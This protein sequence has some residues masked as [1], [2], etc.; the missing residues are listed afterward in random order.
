MSIN[1][2]DKF[3]I[4]SL[5]VKKAIKFLKTKDQQEVNR[6]RS[7]AQA[8]SKAIYNNR[9]TYTTNIFL[10][11]TFLCRNSCDYCG[12]R[13]SSVPRGKEY[14]DP[15]KAKQLI[16]KAKRIGIS[17][18]LLTTGE[19][20]EIDN[21]NARKW[22]N[23][24]GFG[25]TTDYIHYIAKMA[26]D[27]GL[28]P[29]INAG[30]LGTEDF[31]FLRDVSASM[32]LMLEIASSRMMQ[33]GMP[34]ARSPDKHPTRRVL[35]LKTAGMLKIPFTSGLLIG[36]G[37][38]PKEI[39]TSLFILKNLAKKYH[40]LQE[41][42]IQN[43]QPQK[44]SKMKD[45]SPISLQWLE[46][47]VLLARHILPLEVSLQVPP[48]LISRHEANFIKSGISDW[49]G[50][51]PLTRDYINPNYEW[52]QISW[53][54]KISRANGFKLTERLPVYPSFIKEE[55]V[56]QRVFELIIKENLVTEDG[57]RKR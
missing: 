2:V 25:S 22:L 15:S 32:G 51:S 35:S 18:V 23:K 8:I 31:A 10:P 5:T 24:K 40:H 48:N 56:S 47:I 26:L 54:N 20:P 57:Y 7:S 6:W 45:K 16:N 29:H 42:I 11:I 53:L 4:S 33:K 19:K 1:S 44:N 55:W 34:H 49:G 36:I 21:P 12:F 41:V 50:I 13:K 39:V 43:F 27:N 30:S 52:P 38:T 17:E 28:L 46:K 37:E 9:I 14:L 3:L